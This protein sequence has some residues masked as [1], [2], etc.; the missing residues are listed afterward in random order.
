MLLLVPSLGVCGVFFP[1][2]GLTLASPDSRKAWRLHP[3]PTLAKKHLRLE[4]QRALLFSPLTSLPRTRCPSKAR[5]TFKG[6]A[7][8]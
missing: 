6:Q 8:E 3:L 1:R 5:S 4:A 7:G 2:A